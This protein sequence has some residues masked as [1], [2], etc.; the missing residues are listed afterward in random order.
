M[1][2]NIDITDFPSEAH[3]KLYQNA[4]RKRALVPFSRTIDD[5]P[6]ELRVPCLALHGFIMEMYSDMYDNPDCYQSDCSGFLL[7]IGKKGKMEEGG[8]TVP[9]EKLQG[10]TAKDLK[11]MGKRLDALRCLSRVGFTFETLPNGDY[12]FTSEKYPELFPAL[13]LL[14]NGEHSFSLL[15]IHN[16]ENGY[17][18]SHEDYFFLYGEEQRALAY[19]IHNYAEEKKV[20]ITFNKNG[21]IIYHYK[22]KMLMKYGTKRGL[23]VTV[24]LKDKADPVAVVE[25]ALLKEQSGFTAEVLPHMHGCAICPNKHGSGCST[26]TSG[27]YIAVLGKR[28]EM[29]NT[30][31]IGF[32]WHKPVAADLPAIK[33]LIDIRCAL[34]EEAKAAKK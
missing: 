12:R 10:K 17:K 25:Q 20:R 2:F 6:A 8:F 15:R 32:D 26:G 18:P 27:K 5:I 22:S 34:I 29:C 28:H 16:I 21:G 13:K 31:I 33:R 30:E 14:D 1:D 23:S 3:K 11:E 9:A 7:S 24:T 4:R 19:E